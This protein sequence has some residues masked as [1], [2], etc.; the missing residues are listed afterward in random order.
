[1]NASRGAGHRLTAATIE[2]EAALREV[3]GEPDFDA[4]K[5][6]EERAARYARRE[7]FY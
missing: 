7:G 4:V 5:Y 6:D 2:T 3:I 1:M